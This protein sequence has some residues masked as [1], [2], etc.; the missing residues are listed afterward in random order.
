MRGAQPKGEK[1]GWRRKAGRGAAAALLACLAFAGCDVPKQVNPV[2][3]YREVTGLSD[4]GRLPPPGLEQPYPN[5]ASVPPRPE[6]PPP[7]TRAAISAE[8]ERDR[9]QSREPLTLRTVPGPAA[10]GSPPAAPGLSAAPPP[11]PALA[12]APRIPWTEPVPTRQATPS[13][14]AAQ[15]AAEP[16]APR[17][18]ELPEAAPAPPPPDL[19]GAPPP[20]S[21]D[22]LA[23]PRPR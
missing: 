19:L 7:Q 20:P 5:L 3:I 12:A 4:Q 6:R 2:E 15:Q 23:P 16:E 11:R 9:A 21:P 1:A 13:R 10:S 18:P 8:L 17:L 22:L 14:A